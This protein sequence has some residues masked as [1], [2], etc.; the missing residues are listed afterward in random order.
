M[1]QVKP[2]EI[3]EVITDEVFPPEPNYAKIAQGDELKLYKSL[4]WT[5]WE[6]IEYEKDPQK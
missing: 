4:E 6:L 1:T 5:M 2:S 3:K